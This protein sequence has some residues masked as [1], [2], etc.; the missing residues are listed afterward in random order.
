MSGPEG[1]TASLAEVQKDRDFLNRE[2]ELERES[3][4]ATKSQLNAATQGNAELSNKLD[5]ALKQIRDKDLELKLAQ[6]SLKDAEASAEELRERALRRAEDCDRL[7]E[8]MKVQSEELLLQQARIRD[9]HVELSESQC[10]LLPL[11]LELSK[12]TREKELVFR[13]VL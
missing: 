3:H 6:N 4:L 12:V 1:E 5:M 10:K 2:L 7:R 8:E 9:C 13:C 11:Q